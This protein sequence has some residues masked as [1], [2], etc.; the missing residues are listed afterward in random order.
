M[1]QHPFG[2]WLRTRRNTDSARR[3]LYTDSWY[4]VGC[5]ARLT[6]WYMSGPFRADYANPS[7]ENEVVSSRKG[8]NGEAQSAGVKLEAILATDV[9]PSI[10]AIETD[11]RPVISMIFKEQL[12]S[13][14]E[15]LPLI[16]GYRGARKLGAAMAC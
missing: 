4:I 15:P 2:G 5:V 7:A 11:K 16:S 6:A 14:R 10:D 1:R 8:R 13:L 12:A 3:C 9:S